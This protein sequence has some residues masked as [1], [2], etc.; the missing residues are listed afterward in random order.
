ML[1]VQVLLLNLISLTKYSV[2]QQKEKSMEE[3]LSDLQESMG[4]YVEK[5]L[6]TST[7]LIHIEGTNEIQ[8]KI[9]R[10]NEHSN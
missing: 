1:I 8:I 3:L 4:R 9:L 5:N 6:D 10:L 2:F 7:T